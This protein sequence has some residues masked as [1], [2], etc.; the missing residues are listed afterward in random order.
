MWAKASLGAYMK[1]DLRVLR[2]QCMTCNVWKGGMGADFYAK[3]LKEYG[4]V[5]MDRLSKDRNITV[6]AY[7]HYAK[8]LNDY[9]SIQTKDDMIRYNNSR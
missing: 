8:I 6:N 7:D 5:Y 4:H 1:Y 2:P 3:M 9:K